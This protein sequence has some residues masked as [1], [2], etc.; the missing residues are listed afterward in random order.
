MV[1]NWH[2]D[3]AMRRIRA[4]AVTGL[5]KAAHALL[6]ESQSRVPVDSGDLRRSGTVHPA[7]MAELQSAV[8]YSALSEDGYPYG[9]RQH[10]DMTLSHPHGG[11]AKF[12]E[13]PAREMQD[14]LMRVVATE[15]RRAV[16]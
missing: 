14:K 13:K 2:G 5:T 3:E 4:G 1:V 16:G 12:L 9:I 8:S 15:I 6:A 11:E 7:T 10:E